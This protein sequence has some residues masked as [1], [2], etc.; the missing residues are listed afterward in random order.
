MVYSY[1]LNSI[2]VI[3][4]FIF[5]GLPLNFA[6]RTLDRNKNIFI[7]YLIN[8]IISLIIAY[9]LITYFE[10]YGVLLGILITQLIMHA[11][12]AYSLKNELK[13]LWK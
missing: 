13:F 10:I 8:A 12:N 4:I 11:W 6:V 5:I 3:Y 1:V 7:S 2:S 9:P